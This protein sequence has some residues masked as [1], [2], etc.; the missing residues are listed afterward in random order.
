MSAWLPRI[1]SE[2][3]RLRANPWRRASWCGRSWRPLALH[4]ALVY[5]LTVNWSD[6][7]ARHVQVK[8]AP[9]VIKAR[10]IDVAEYAAEAG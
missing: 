6:N 3:F 1:P 2:R 10:L 9:K 4:A 8:P 7:G 5:T